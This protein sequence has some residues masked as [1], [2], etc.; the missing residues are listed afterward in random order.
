[1]LSL[2][3]TLARWKE[4]S[5]G[6]ES[7]LSGAVCGQDPRYCE[8]PVSVKPYE[9]PD[10]ITQWPICKQRTLFV[11]ENVVHMQCE[12]TGRPCCIQLHG[13]CRITTRD[14]C[15]FVEGYFHENATLC[16]QVTLLSLLLLLTNVSFR[17]PVTPKIGFHNSFS[18]IVQEESLLNFLA[19]D[20]EKDQ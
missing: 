18:N 20:N 4:D 7:R 5:P 12:I 10:D 17:M 6:P 13:Q 14:Y 9:W 19:K 16:S 3:A 1:M 8:N 2:I 11:P 15:D